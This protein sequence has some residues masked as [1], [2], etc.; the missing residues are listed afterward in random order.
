MPDFYR[1]GCLRLL[2]AHVPAPEPAGLRRAD[3]R[4]A[5]LDRI[6][7]NTPLQALDLLNDPIFVEAAPVLGGAGVA[8][9]W[10]DD[11]VFAGRSPG[12]QT[13][14][15]RPPS[16]DAFDAARE[17]AAP[18]PAGTGEGGAIRDRRRSPVP[19][20]VHPPE[21]AAMATVT[22]AVLNLHEMITRN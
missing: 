12:A 17:C 21:L 15:E 9:G 14:A 13:S 18:V 20:D 10:R 11:A 2:A 5:R 22:R 3:A 6:T 1:R 19:R 8:P 4:G 16:S 7:S